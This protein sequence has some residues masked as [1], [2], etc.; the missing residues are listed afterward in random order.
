V[1]ERCRSKWDAKKNST[2]SSLFSCGKIAMDNSSTPDKPR[3]YPFVRKDALELV[4]MVGPKD[5]L[6][7]HL[8]G[9]EGLQLKMASIYGPAGMGKTTLADLVY[10]AIGD[11]FQ[12]RAFVSVTPGGNMREVLITI[13]EQVAPNR[14]VPLVGTAEAT[15]EEHL[16]DI[17]SNFLKDKRCANLY[18]QLDLTFIYMCDV[19]NY[20]QER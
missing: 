10:E 7:R 6:I 13:L 20:A 4:G 14:S 8:I 18:P 1:S 3:A 15:E 9:K 19:P 5:K 11:K 16:I 17:I 12:S 2:V